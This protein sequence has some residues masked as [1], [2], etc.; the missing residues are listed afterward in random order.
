RHA[1]HTYTEGDS[2]VR[3]NIR[4]CIGFESRLSEDFFLGS[5]LPRA[6]GYPGKEE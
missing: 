3:H 6:F 5:W 4:H 2:N 1:G